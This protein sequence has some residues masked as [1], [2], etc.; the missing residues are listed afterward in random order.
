MCV[1]FPLFLLMSVFVLFLSLS[2]CYFLLFFLL[3]PLCYFSPFGSL[4]CVYSSLYPKACLTLFTPLYSS[5]KL[6]FLS[7]LW[8]RSPM[9]L[10]PTFAHPRAARFS[11]H[12]LPYVDVSSM[13]YCQ[14]PYC[15]F[16]IQLLSKIYGSILSLPIQTIGREKCCS[17][18]TDKLSHSSCSIGDNCNH[19]NAAI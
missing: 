8:T 9:H 1:L 15:L 4:P 12:S 13:H 6:Y 14:S 10:C 19:K 3:H 2:L 5:P 11:Q 16:P 17:L 18:V 7:S